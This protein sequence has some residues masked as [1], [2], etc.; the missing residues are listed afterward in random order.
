MVRRIRSRFADS[1]KAVPVLLGIVI[2]CLGAVADVYYPRVGYLVRQTTHRS[3]FSHVSS[4]QSAAS[5][6]PLPSQE[7]ETG[8]WLVIEK[9]GIKAALREGSDIGVLDREEGAWHQAGIV[10]QDNFVV[11]GHRFQ[12]LPP[13]THT[14][15]NLDKVVP[16][17]VLT[18]WWEGQRFDFRVYQIRT[19]DN[20]DTAI[21]LPGEQPRLTLYTC[22]DSSLQKRLVILAQPTNS[23]FG[24]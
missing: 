19:V 18:V 11:A 17:D 8:N 12:F 5:V 23:S 2:L 13:N 10:G 3:P 20:T 7:K 6:N 21:L 15:F 22:T 4:A 24:S 9:V 1:R 14:F 16:G